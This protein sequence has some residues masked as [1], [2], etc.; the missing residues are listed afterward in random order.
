[1]SCISA[2]DL[3]ILFVD[4][5]GHRYRLVSS[6]GI[7][8]TVAGTGTSGYSGD[9]GYGTS[10]EF[11][12]PNGLC[13]D[14]TLLYLLDAENFRVR[15]LGTSTGI[16]SFIAGSGSSTLTDGVGIGASFS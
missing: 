13:L 2:T 15:R 16:V 1:M 7:I 6:S 14:G 9:G 11:N 3:G 12:S 8:T 5:N 10:A 4:Q